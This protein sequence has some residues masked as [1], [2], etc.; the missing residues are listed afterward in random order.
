MN[1]WNDWQRAVPLS[2]VEHDVGGVSARFTSNDGP[3]IVLGSPHD[4]SGSV[5]FAGIAGEWAKDRQNHHRFRSR[6]L[7]GGPGFAI[8]TEI[9]NSPI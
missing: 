6:P 2:F 9:Q 1:N 3:A 8:L 5:P 4:S 7:F